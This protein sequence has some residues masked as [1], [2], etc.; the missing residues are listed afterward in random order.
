M[1]P[2][3]IFT[4]P[5][6]FA[7]YQLILPFFQISAWQLDPGLGMIFSFLLSFLFWSW[8]LGS[9]FIPLVKRQFGFGPG[10]R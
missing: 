5:G 3:D 7:L 1:T 10:R 2:Y 9:V 6:T 4:I 8:L